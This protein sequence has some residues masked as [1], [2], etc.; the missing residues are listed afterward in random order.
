MKII[1][2]IITCF[3]HLVQAWWRKAS[4]LGIRRKS[5][6]KNTKILIFNLEMLPFMEYEKPNK[7]LYIIKKFKRIL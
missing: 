3:F 1:F 4:K 2:F 6:I 7:F 5:Y